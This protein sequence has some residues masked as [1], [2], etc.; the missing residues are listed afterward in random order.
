MIKCYQNVLKAGDYYRKVNAQLTLE[1]NNHE[2]HIAS[3]DAWAT[4]KEMIAKLFK[5]VIDYHMKYDQHGIR[6]GA[7]ESS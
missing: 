7:G 5:G 1:G 6:Q 3:F 4:Y 2:L